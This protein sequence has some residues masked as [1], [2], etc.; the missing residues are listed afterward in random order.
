M[1]TDETREVRRF[2]GRTVWTC[3]R[4]ERDGRHGSIE[5]AILRPQELVMD[6]T[7][8][9]TRYSVRLARTAE[10]IYQGTWERQEGGRAFRGVAECSAGSFESVHAVKSNTPDDARILH[11]NGSWEEEGEW[12]WVGRMEEVDV[13]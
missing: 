12:W 13:F 8:G 1:T 11:L 6:L 2:K 5:R 9:T 4:G 10:D 7:T 3:D